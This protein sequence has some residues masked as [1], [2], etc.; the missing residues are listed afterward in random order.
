MKESETI[1]EYADMLMKAVNQLGLYGEELSE[2]RIVEK[3]RVSVLE[4]LD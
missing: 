3:V 2:K 1:K 4:R